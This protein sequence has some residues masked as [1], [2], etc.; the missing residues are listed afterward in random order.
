MSFSVLGSRTLGHPRAGF[1]QLTVY[2]DGK[3]ATVLLL[4]DSVLVTLVPRPLMK[5]LN[6]VERAQTAGTDSK[7]SVA[8]TAPSD[9][10]PADSKKS[11]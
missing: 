3:Q 10:L 8:S 2:S 4:M 1:L 11:E 6:S 5:R 7:A 9:C